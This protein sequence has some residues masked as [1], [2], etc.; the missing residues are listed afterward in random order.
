[1]ELVIHHSYAYKSDYA[2]GKDNHKVLE[3][4]L[5]QA[6]SLLKLEFLPGQDFH[7]Q[8]LF[9]P[10][11]TAYLM[12]RGFLYSEKYCKSLMATSYRSRLFD[13]LPISKDIKGIF[14]RLAEP[15]LHQNELRAMIERKL[16]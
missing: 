7:K 15:D 11:S 2:K 14:L 5:V 10:E 3:E 1:M 8:I 16:R 6:C 4:E 12:D 9:T 13:T